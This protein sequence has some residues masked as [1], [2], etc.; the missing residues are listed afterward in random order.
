MAFALSGA[1]VTKTSNGFYIVH[2]TYPTAGT[3]Y[4]VSVRNA[5]EFYTEALRA[6]AAIPLGS[7]NDTD[8][9]TFSNSTTLSNAITAA[10]LDTST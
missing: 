6:I 9:Q 10:N 7:T 2:F 8:L 1:G 5:T 4:V 3:T